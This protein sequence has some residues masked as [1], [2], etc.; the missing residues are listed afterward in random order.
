MVGTRRGTAYTPSAEHY[1]RYARQNSS[2]PG[3]KKHQQ[4][5]KPSTRASTA[6][7]QSEAPLPLPPPP[8][9][10]DPTNHGERLTRSG[11]P[12]CSHFG[13]LR[14]QR[15]PGYFFCA[16]CDWFDEN[17]ALGGNRTKRSSRRYECRANHQ[18]WLFPSDKMFDESEE[19]DVGSVA[20]EYE[21]DADDITSGGV[22]TTT[23]KVIPPLLENSES[24]DSNK[25][26]ADLT[27]ELEELKLKLHLEQK[28]AIAGRKNTT[29]QRRR[30]QVNK[31]KKKKVV[32]VIM[33]RWH[34]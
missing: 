14:R 29:K 9:P 34:L 5:Q 24:T 15:Y 22:V 33:K 28:K 32:G 12:T 4:A 8:T 26:F 19:L 23:T 6:K 16:N 1:G 11:S 21:E 20:A 2:L 31:N 18:S 3:Q 27:K 13:S 17:K 7:R 10:P 25:S 30:Q